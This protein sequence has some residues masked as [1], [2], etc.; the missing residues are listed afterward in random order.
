MDTTLQPAPDR[1]RGRRRLA[2]ALVAVIAAVGPGIAWIHGCSSPSRGSSTAQGKATYYCPMHT[3]YQSDRP[4]NCPIC[5]MKLVPLEAPSG[6]PS[7]TQV[8]TPGRTGAPNANSTSAGTGTG[9]TI[10][11][12]PERQQQ[13]GVKFAEATLLPAI[14]E[15]RAVGKVAYDETQIAHVHTKVQGWIEDVFVNF[16][17]ASVR[18]GQ[19]LFTIYS[20]DLVAAQE[21]YLLSLRAQKELATSSFERVSEGSRELLSATRRRLELWDITPA[22][23][24]ALEKRGEVSR[25]VTI[26]S[27]VS[28]IVTER[29]AYHHGRTVTPELDLYTIVDLS[30]VW[31]LAQV[32]EYE[33]PHVRVGQDGEATFPYE[34]DRRPLLGKVTFVSPVLDPKTRTVEIRMEFANPD[35]ALK[36]ETFVNVSLRRDLGKRLVVPKDAVMDTGAK[37][38]VFVDKGEGYLEPREVRAGVE[39]SA[40]RVIADGLRETERVVTAAN[41]ILDSESRLKGAFDAMGKPSTAEGQPAGAAPQISADVSTDPSPARVGRNRVHVKLADASGQAIKGADV[42]IRFFM[43]QMMGMAQVDVKA[44][45]REAGPGEYAGEVNLPIAW[46]FATTVTVVRGGQVVGTAETTVTAR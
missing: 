6:G 26:A 10:R 34:A 12:A 1:P 23:I 19:P 41:F 17:G 14:V 45:L 13:I 33:L 21:E 40:G 24:E 18:K 39:V 11:I 25:T 15:I 44:A 9:P 22:Q 38:Y 3:H 32:Y 8:E 20:P 43:P 35:L 31:V 4:G 30:R 2:V 37:Q 42:S 46:S 27:Q 29:A 7:A 16:V 36:P 5:S 28:G